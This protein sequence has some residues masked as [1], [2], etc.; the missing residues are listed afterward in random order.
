MMDDKLSDP[1]L[2]IGDTNKVVFR[3]LFSKILR[4]ETDDRPWDDFSAGK[5]LRNLDAVIR[6]MDRLGSET[7]I[8]SSNKAF[9]V[10]LVNNRNSIILQKLRENAATM[11]LICD[12]DRRYRTRQIKQMK[13]VLYQTTRSVPSS[14]KEQSVKKRSKHNV[15][16]VA[17]S[18]GKKRT[19]AGPKYKTS[20]IN[21]EI[22]HL[23][24]EKENG[25]SNSCC[26]SNN[27]T[28]IEDGII[29]PHDYDMNDIQVISHHDVPLESI[30]ALYCYYGDETFPVD[31]LAASIATSSEIDAV[32]NQL[33][34][35]E[36]NGAPGNVT[37][38][39][40][41]ENGK[42]E[43]QSNSEYEIINSD[44]ES[45]DIILNYDQFK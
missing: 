3:P 42:T 16:K 2:N 17:N 25:M 8:Y 38:S 19:L 5:C 32:I 6:L 27:Q 35:T 31:G 34:A 40:I 7:L 33:I 10:D 9:L 41:T 30:E 21:F 14:F 26:E 15:R 22:P 24:S 28:V 44:Q 45:V 23:E 36:Y 39:A 20:Q 37:I 11:R 29:Q 18:I 43:L 4:G 12:M 1:A 13:S